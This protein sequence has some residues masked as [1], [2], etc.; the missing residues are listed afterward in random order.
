M[1]NIFRC[2]VASKFGEPF[3][4]IF[5]G[6]IA[7][8][9]SVNFGNARVAFVRADIN[10]IGLD[11]LG[12][13]R[14]NIEA[15][16]FILADISP[17]SVDAG[18]V[19]ETIP[20]NP[21]VFYEIGYAKALEKPLIVIS[22]GPERRPPVDLVDCIVQWYTWGDDQDVEADHLLSVLTPAVR[23]AIADVKREKRILKP[24]YP[25]T[26]YSERT[27]ADIPERIA[28]ARHMINILQTNLAT[29][30]SNYLRSIEQ[31]IKSPREDGEEFR[32]RILTLDPDS[33]FT[34]FRAKHLNIEVAKYRQELHKSIRAVVK[35]LEQYPEVEIRV[36]DDFPEQIVFMAD[37]VVFDCTVAQNF[38][39][40]KL[41]TFKTD[42]KNLGAE[43][44]FLFHF[45]SLWS[46]AQ[47][48]KGELSPIEK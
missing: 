6:G 12:S 17:Y 30:R 41:C 23:E 16:D 40:R 21:N 5:T 8:L 18:G 29:V 35:A 32:V 7:P 4:S 46:R 22:H 25:V 20:F 27:A 33:Y 31:A 43:R 37:D 38:R 48:Y 39:S 45:E 24:S 11:F 13:V 10:L 34:S 2:F 26:C 14:S 47:P 9:A 15:A 44:S 36:Y 3:D 28:A 19:E 1:P 42:L